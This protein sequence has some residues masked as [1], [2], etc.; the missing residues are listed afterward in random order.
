MRNVAVYLKNLS[1]I[2]MI[3]GL[4]TGIILIAKPE[5]SVQFICI[6][7]GAVLI[8]LGIGSVISYFTKL[9]LTFLAVIG[10][11]L[12]IIGV[13]VC[14]R[15]DR[16]VS[17]VIFLFGLFVTI[18]G[19]VDFVSALDARKNN[20]KS[21]IFSIVMSVGVTILGII[22]LVN[23]FDS[24]ILLTRLLGLSLII[25]AMLDLITLIQVRKIFKLKTVKLDGVDEINIDRE[26]IE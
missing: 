8:L 7:F 5:Q 3:A 26:D 11:I 21:W 23:P 4:I 20:L 19:I 18:S 13:M 12:V 6:I 9:K 17:A 10:V 1:L 22:V 2:T 25:Y 15:Y 16:L 24:A 14:I